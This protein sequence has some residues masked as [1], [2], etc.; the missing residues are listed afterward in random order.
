MT[1]DIYSDSGD[2]LFDI[3]CDDDFIEAELS[4]FDGSS[5]NMKGK[6]KRALQAR[7]KIERLMERKRMRELEGDN[8]W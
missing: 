4:K 6:K 1:R 3:T 5:I 2:E 7:R 8:L